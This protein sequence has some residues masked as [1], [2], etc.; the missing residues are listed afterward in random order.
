MYPLFYHSYRCFRYGKTGGGETR[1]GTHL[2]GSLRVLLGPLH[3]YN[4]SLQLTGH[5][6]HPVQSLCHLAREVEEGEG[7]VEKRGTRRREGRRKEERRKDGK[8]RRGRGWGEGGEGGERKE[9]GREGRCEKEGGTRKEESK[10]MRMA[11]RE[12]VGRC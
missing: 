2:G 1:T 6:H 3:R 10:T 5:P 9:E 4:V 8:R 12:E 11:E 7:R